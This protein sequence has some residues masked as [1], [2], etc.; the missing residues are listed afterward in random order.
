MTFIVPISAAKADPERP[1][2]MMAVK[3][4]ENSRIITSPIMLA[5]KIWAPNISSGCAASK[6]MTRPMSRLISDTI[7]RALTPAF[8]KT[9]ATSRQRMTRGRRTTAAKPWS[10]PP[11]KTIWARASAS[12][13]TVAA[14]TWPRSDW[15]G[16]GWRMAASASGAGK[17]ES[18]VWNSGRRPRTVAFTPGTTCPCESS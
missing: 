4:G 13:D 10:T 16:G 17:A 18:S 11:R 9:T 2:K 14:P 15:R 8:S 12:I 7:G 3:I 6:A 5:M 1:A